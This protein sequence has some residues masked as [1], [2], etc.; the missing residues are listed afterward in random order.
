MCNLILTQMKRIF[1]LSFTLL[2]FSFIGYAHVEGVVVD[3]QGEPLVGANLHWKGTTNGTT[4]DADGRFEIEPV[5][6]TR[7]LVTSYIGYRSDTTEIVKSEGVV[8]VLQTENAELED[9]NIAARRLAVVR[10]RISAFNTERLTSDE[11][12]RA[13]CCNL[14]ESFETS[15]AVDVAYADAATGAKQIRLLGLAGRY[16]Q[17]LGEN[18]PG[19]RG[20]GQNLGMESIPGPWMESIQVSKGTSSVINGYESTTGQINVEYLK[21]KTQ[22]PV[23]VNLMLN[24]ELHAEVNLTGG[25]DVSPR[26]M[27]ESPTRATDGIYTGLLAHYQDGSLPM[28]HNHDTFLDMPLN[29]QLNIINRWEFFKGEYTGRLLLH[30]LYDQRRGGQRQAATH[31]VTLPDEP[32]LIDL[33]TRR[34]DGFMKNGYVINDDKQM[35]IGIIAAGSYH[36]L[37]NTYGDRQ[38][39]ASQANAYLNAMFQTNFTDEHKLTAGLSLN[40]DTYRQTLSGII[41]RDIATLNSNLSN[42]QFDFSHRQTD[43]GLFAEYSYNPNDKLTL[44]AGMRADLTMRQLSLSANSTPVVRTLPTP[45]LNIRYSPFAWWNMRA[46]VGMGY[47]TP[48]VVADN[49]QYLPTGRVF[50]QPLAPTAGTYNTNIFTPQSASLFV[51]QIESALN[52]GLTTTFYIPIAEREL[53]LNAE[54]FYTHF[55][56]CL[57]ADTENAGRLILYNL[58]EINGAQAFAHTW[59]VE[60]TMEI[61]RGWTMTLAYRQNDT[62]QTTFTED[63]YVLREKPLQNKFKAI[64]TT[65]YQTPLKKWQF[66]L[67]AQFNGPGR[68]PQSFK[69]PAGAEDQYFTRQLTETT[70]DGKQLTSNIVYHRWYPQLLAQ[71]TKY[72]RTCSLY[73]GA[74]NMTNF[75]Q[76]QPII[77]A[78]TTF[79]SSFDAATVWAPATGWKLYVGFRWNLAAIEN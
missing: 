6:T 2:L 63:G 79:D 19:I 65:S 10:S 35:S 75:M 28:D 53:Q 68:M 32:Y 22:D 9:V 44:L 51:P 55:F 56:D 29:R 13:A 14:S 72:W 26:S 46:S 45:R 48:D 1:L 64:I 3:M 34:V 66:D 27:K 17:L 36:S 70:L 7:M 20:I 25:W 33:R 67:T 69:I 74:E 5:H 42:A 24:T 54:Y 16:V 11:L 43:L 49:A 71:V 40:H 37:D 15:A 38:W 77:S 30:G 58:S 47:R 4:T 78:T 62:R 73:V 23:A 8:I 50:S 61:L 59:Q 31:A 21:P 39:H 18:T 76:K 52:A 12:C 57:M 60:A 41:P